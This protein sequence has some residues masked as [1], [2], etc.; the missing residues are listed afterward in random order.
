MWASGNR[1][2]DRW[3][4]DADALDLDRKGVAKHHLA[5]GRGNHRCLGAPLARL[6][7][8]LAFQRVLERMKNIR[9]APG[10]ETPRHLENILF[11][12]PKEVF[13]EFDAA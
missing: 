7:G 5:F 13:I 12:A 6:E 4:D 3:G 2:P 11:R 1:D 10:H 8:R 9:L